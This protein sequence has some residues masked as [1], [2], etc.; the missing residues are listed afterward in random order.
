MGGK[1]KE[2]V[3]FPPTERLGTRL[4]PLVIDTHLNKA[5]PKGGRFAVL[6]LC[7]CTSVVIFYDLCP[8]VPGVKRGLSEVSV[9]PAVKRQRGCSLYEEVNGV[10][11]EEEVLG[12]EDTPPDNQKNLFCGFSFLLTLRTK[13]DR[14]LGKS[15]FYPFSLSLHPSPLSLTIC[16]T[17]TFPFSHTP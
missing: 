14:H 11:E 16:P 10:R 1:G 5:C 4:S 13:E 12:E 17:L 6:M 9:S 2:K 8:R 15:Y 7:T 3:S